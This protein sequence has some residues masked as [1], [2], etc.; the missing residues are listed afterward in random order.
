MPGTKM[1]APYVPDTTVLY[2]EG[3][4]ET[5]G[6]ELIDLKGD[7]VAMLD[8]LRDYLWNIEGD[9]NIDGLIKAYFAENGYDFDIEDEG[10][11]EDEDD[12]WEDED[13]EG[14]DWG[15]DEDW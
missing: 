11:Y 12:G 14:D 13:G 3:A 15:D 10:D 4:K 2:S 8:G 9:K 6:S 7:T 1:P 5:W